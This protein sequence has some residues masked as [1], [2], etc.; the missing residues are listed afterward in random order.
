MLKKLRLIICLSAMSLL[1][2]DSSGQCYPDRHSTNWYDGWISCEAFPNPNPQH[3]ISHW[4]MYDFGQVYALKNSK[5]WN[6]NDPNHLNRGMKDVIIDVSDDGADWTSAGRYTF[7]QA[8]GKNTYQGFDG[9]DFT[10]TSA[11]YLL[12]TAVDNWGGACYGL[13]EIRF[14]AEDVATSIAESNALED[15]CFSVETYPNPFSVK[16]RIIIQ[17]QCDKEINYRITDVLGRSIE[18]GIIG[19]VSGYHTIHLNGSM[20]VPGNYIVA[21]RQGNQF[22]QQHILRIE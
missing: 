13:S 17:S 19:G 1:A 18:S 22:A 2:Y 8:N 14:E 3:G 5:I 16:S 12:I 6:S 9:P 20:L 10:G 7:A 11:R 21:I 15:R 4:I